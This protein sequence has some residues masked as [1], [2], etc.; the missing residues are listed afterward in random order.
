MKGVFLS[1]MNHHLDELD[2]ACLLEPAERIGIS[3]NIPKECHT[4]KVRFRCVYLPQD[5]LQ[6]W[7]KEELSKNGVNL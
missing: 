4:C 7:L 3:E 5:V 6:K 1:L 2:A